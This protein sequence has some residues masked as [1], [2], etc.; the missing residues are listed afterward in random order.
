MLRLAA[1]NTF[2]IDQFI[3]QKAEG[4]RRLGELFL[5]W[6]V[7]REPEDVD[8][9]EDFVDLSVEEGMEEPLE[10]AA[11]APSPAPAG[12]ARPA[13]VYVMAAQAGAAAAGDNESVAEDPE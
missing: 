8:E 9:E 3:L 10:A 7:G 6:S 11:W 12:R 1:E 5:S 13:P 2:N 4:K